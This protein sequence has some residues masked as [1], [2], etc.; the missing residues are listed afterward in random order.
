MAKKKKIYTKKRNTRKKKFS[1]WGFAFKWA[2]ILALWVGIFLGG[3][4]LWY[5]RDLTDITKS[6]T[7]EKRALIIVKS[8]D[9]TDIARYGE[10]KGENVH[11][12]EL[13][14][15]LVHAILAIE[16][17]R[18]YQH[19]GIDIIGI[20]RAMAM[21][22]I[23]GGFVQGGSTITQQLA[24][25]LFLSNHRVLE[26]KIKEALL[27]I[28]LERE[29]S[30]DDILSAYINRVY[31]GSGTY[32]FEAASQLY[33]GKSAKDVNLREASIL[34]GLLKAPSRYSPHNN[35][36]LAKERGDVVLQA[37]QDAGYI[38]KADMTP[39][40]M[41]VS[42]PHQNTTTGQD[43][44]Y[45]ADWVL[46]GLEDL[47][48]T[49]GMDM[50][51]QTTLDLE[52]QS[53]AQKALKSTIDNADEL[54]FVTQGAV[55]SMQPDGAILAMVGGYD[56]TQSQFNRALQAKRPPGSSFKSIVFLTAL[57]K[58]W[59]PDDKI[60][61]AP[62]EDGKYRPKNFANQYYGEITL[63]EAIGLS[64]N[65]ATVR[66]AKELGMDSIINTA[67]KVGIISDLQRDLSLALG[68]SGVSMLEMGLAYA[69]FANGGYRVFP[70]GI[71]KISTPEG[72]VLYE[73]K[74]PTGYKPIIRKSHIDDLTKM[75][76]TVI[77]KGT[78]RRAKLP[79]PAAGKTGTS[80]DS[81]DAWFAGY[82][83][84]IVTIVWLGNDDNSP[85]RDITGGSLPADIWK[86]VM[87]RGEKK[88]DA[89]Q[90]SGQSDNVFSGLLG[91]IIAG[92]ADSENDFS[93]LNQ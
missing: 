23:K 84:E 42:L 83:D 78:G 52:I 20:S 22:V 18:F 4:I 55:L 2:F 67:R 31:L 57:E 45:F 91:R 44:R 17:R 76:E 61:D 47:V 40:N 82:T 14:K 90:I 9:G 50:I 30:K 43:I 51:I 74:P 72:R 41:T 12:R 29:L 8:A 63:E 65:T 37:M 5:A 11:V 70:Y 35:L 25:N 48:G 36:D 71:T 1:L 32:G 24:K 77:N 66:L 59:K 88:Y 39:D 54:Q 34:A 81:R 92:G 64:A 49:P 79:F 73:R 19:P 33:F 93:N 85:M 69:V 15:Y 28:W 46:D 6:A 21:N 7:F 62:I 16:D 13:P 68:S 3:V 75:L 27:A 80:Q 56:Y 58:G 53:T 87:L 60:L 86:Q 26:R 10:S 38:T 89:P